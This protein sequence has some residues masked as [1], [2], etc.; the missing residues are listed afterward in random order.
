METFGWTGLLNAGG[1]IAAFLLCLFHL[2]VHF[3]RPLVFLF[4][5][6]GPVTQAAIV[7]IIS[8]ASLSR[9]ASAPS[10]TFAGNFDQR[11]S[12]RKCNCKCVS[13]CNSGVTV[14]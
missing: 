1:E 5:C 12:K 8:I 14:V 13:G 2:V 10:A 11:K 3:I 7:L 9:Y 4:T 6:A